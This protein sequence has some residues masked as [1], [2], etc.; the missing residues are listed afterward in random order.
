MGVLSDRTITS[1]LKFAMDTN[2]CPMCAS[3]EKLLSCRIYET[4]S[5]G[6]AMTVHNEVLGLTVGYIRQRIFA[7]EDVSDFRF[8]C[9]FQL[10]K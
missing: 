1:Q 3:A 2:H 4:G 9:Y 6:Q 8:D 7:T 5:K 10:W